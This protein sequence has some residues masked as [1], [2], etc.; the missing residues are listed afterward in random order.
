LREG[1]DV[2]VESK[3]SKLVE[4]VTMS[5]LLNGYALGGA[6]VVLVA[7]SLS[8]PLGAAPVAT[9]KAIQIDSRAR[10]IDGGFGNFVFT[11][12]KDGDLGR[13]TFTRS[14]EGSGWKVASDGMRYGTAT[15]MDT[16]KGRNGT[17]VMRAVGTAY[18]MGLGDSEVW[19]GTWSV[20]SGTG[21]Y[22]GMTG[23]GRWFGTA[24]Q[25]T[26]LFKRSTGFV[27]P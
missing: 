16:L 18:Q 5:R 19:A 7:L 4:E 14:F 26:T 22:S 10:G 8:A 20:V 15:E 11:L 3:P 2:A 23:G 9:K 17:L 21:D 27:R 13:V 25:T 1:H 24:N 6:S 12:G